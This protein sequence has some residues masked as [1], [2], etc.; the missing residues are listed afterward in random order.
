MKTGKVIILPNA[1]VW[2]HELST[3]KALANAGHTVEFRVNK[4]IEFVKSPDILIDSATWEMKSPKSTKLVAVERNLKKAYHQ[5]K[6]IV[7]DSQRM[8]RLPDKSIQKELVK[9]FQLTKNIKK[10]LFVNR[11]RETIDISTLV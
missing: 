2:P 4:N 6:N 8:G 11:K 7:F 1:A 9:Q 5:S 3:A 10:L